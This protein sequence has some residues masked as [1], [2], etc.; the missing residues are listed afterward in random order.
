MGKQTVPFARRLLTPL[1]PMHHVGCTVMGMEIMQIPQHDFI[2][3]VLPSAALSTA[4]ALWREAPALTPAPADI[5][6]PYQKMSQPAALD[7]H[8]ISPCNATTDPFYNS[9]P[10]W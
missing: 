5:Y 2:C 3:N 1:E 8:V 6:P 9:H 10:L 4:L 7:V